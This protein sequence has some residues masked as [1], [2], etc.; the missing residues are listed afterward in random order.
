ME[1][2][3][4]ESEEL[5]NITSKI[6]DELLDLKTDKLNTADS[7]YNARICTLEKQLSKINS[8]LKTLENDTVSELDHAENQSSISNWEYEIIDGGKFCNFSDG[9]MFVTGYS[10]QEFIDNNN[11]IDKIVFSEDKEAFI[12]HTPNCFASNS[13]NQIVFRIITKSGALRWISH[14]CY[15]FYNH[16]VKSRI[17]KVSNIDIT[18][19]K[20][21]EEWLRL[22]SKALEVASIGIV[23]TDNKGK[24]LW[25]NSSFSRLTGYT[26]LEVIG[27]NPKIFKSDI[28]GPGFYKKMWDTILSGKSWKSEIINKKKSGEE[29]YEMMTISPVIE[30][31]GKLTHFIAIKEDITERKEAEEQIQRY[32]EEIYE[33]K[34]LVEQNAHELVELNVKLEQSEDKLMELN[35]NKDKFFSIIAHDLKNPFTALIGFTD[36]MLDDFDGF[37]KEEIIEYMLTMSKTS[38]NVLSLLEGLLDWS[39]LQLGNL[40]LNPSKLSLSKIGNKVFDLYENNAKQKGIRLINSLD[41]ST[42]IFSDENAVFTTLRNLVSN[43]IKFTPHGGEV[44][45]FSKVVENEFCQIT[46]KDNG[47]GM[48]EK[49]MDKL[50]KIEVHHTT[51]GTDKE[52]GTGLG[53]LLCKDL[54]E[55]SGGKIWIESKVGK[56]SEFIFTVPLAK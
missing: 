34:D 51:I 4:S 12:N 55:K 52:K 27:K 49:T 50:F 40:T 26:S 8:K 31:N 10:P 25:V 41:N 9:T 19:Q 33:N 53:L 23:I 38:K 24:I 54:T 32:I 7:E 44:N 13:A 6:T 28:H 16:G 48:D 46:V 15:P 2:F 43:A 5:R 30:E 47:I 3:Q 1:D 20:E 29:Y 35:A 17:R 18:D 22:K 14:T 42:T 36:M 37:S 11:L 39:R 56:G 21:R 45:F